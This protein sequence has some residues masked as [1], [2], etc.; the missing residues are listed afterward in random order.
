MCLPSILRWHSG[1]GSVALRF[2]SRQRT[3]P[4]PAGHGSLQSGF[5]GNMMLFTEVEASRVDPLRWVSD[6]GDP[7]LLSHSHCAS[8]LLASR[9]L[10]NK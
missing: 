7:E 10:S 9:I 5:R 8:P 4:T 3:A 6:H 1:G 2:G